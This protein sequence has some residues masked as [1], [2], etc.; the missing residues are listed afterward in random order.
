MVHCSY[1]ADHFE[2]QLLMGAIAQDAIG[3]NPIGGWRIEAGGATGGCAVQA[4]ALSVA[5]GVYDYSIILG[6]E[7][8]SQV[9]TQQGT[10][11]IALA[12]DTDFDF[13]AGGN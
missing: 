13:E 3:W 11:F 5:S 9:S 4:A 7:K 12:S 6:W 2:N 10:E 8:M 1:F